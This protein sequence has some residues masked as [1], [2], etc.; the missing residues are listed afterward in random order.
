[1]TDCMS[2][3]ICRNE[4]IDEV[5]TADHDFEQEGFAILL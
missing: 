2:M 3:V 1:M 4:K 5:L